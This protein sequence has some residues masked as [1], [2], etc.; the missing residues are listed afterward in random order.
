[1]S[2]P[3]RILLASDIY[4]PQ[5][6]GI[7]DSVSILRRE[8]E[9]LGHRVRI[10]A[11][12]FP[13]AEPD[14]AVARLPALA[15]P[16]WGGLSVV[17]P[18]GMK[19]AIAA[20]DADIVH[21]HTFST[22]GFAA[23]R[24]ARALTLPVVGTDH[25][26]PAAYLHYAGLD[27]APLRDGLDRLAAS[28]YKRCEAVTAPSAAVIASL[29]AQSLD[30]PASVV[31]N[32]VDTALFA[33]LSSADREDA[34]TELALDGPAILLFGRLAAEKDLDVAL[35]AFA[36]LPRELRATLVVV[37]DGPARQ[38]FE[39]EI[40]LRGLI[41]RI[42][43]LGTLR[44][45]ALCRAVGA[46]DVAVIASRSETQSMTTIQALACGLPVVAARAGG[47]PE[48]V[49]D[50]ETGFLAPPQDPP[51]FAER[52]EALLTDEPLRSRLA[53]AAPESVARFT[54][55]AV[56]RAFETLYRSAVEHGLGAASSE[57][58]A[59]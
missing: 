4:L 20:F 32:P 10:V 7:A 48:Y 34:R 21:V 22:L 45:P 39:A 49:S 27:F 44:G 6:S 50:G 25:T 35:E 30:R 58:T 56:A 24:A 9:G 29:R 13:D 51:A 23:L 26:Y 11:P 12:E 42:R 1:M 41:P 5:L 15:V 54:P 57:K 28:F 55:T 43:L 31:S 59:A 17:W 14:P 16:G 53:A 2:R 47:L 18:K 19:S 52:L 36:R 3:M 46:C 38:D 8:L 40:R 33:P 37:G